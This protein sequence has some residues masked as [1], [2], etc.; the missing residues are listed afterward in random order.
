MSR[1]SGIFQLDLNAIGRVS[2]PHFGAIFRNSGIVNDGIE[3][4]AGDLSG[5]RHFAMWSG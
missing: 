3:G 5:V 2:G 1:F 4:S